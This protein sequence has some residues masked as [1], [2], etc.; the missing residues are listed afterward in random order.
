MIIGNGDIAS[1]LREGGVDRD[2]LLF[3]A[4]GVSNSQETRASE[5]QREI[6]LFNDYRYDAR[7][8]VY[9]S[10][11]C[12]FYSET[13][14]ACHK[15]DMEEWTREWFDKFTILRMG[16][17]TWGNNPF[18]LINYLKVHPDAEIKDEYRYICDKEEFLHWL[19]LLPE[20][21]CEMNVPGRRMKVA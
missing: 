1:A 15:R 18:T 12:V 6:D 9:I 13:R 4:A 14:Y 19:N 5:Y 8:F 17:I 3:F 11:L 21:S 2:G 16:N 10:S 7:R 20:W